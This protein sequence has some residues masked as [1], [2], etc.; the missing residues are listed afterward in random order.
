MRKKP[1]GV[2]KDVN[3]NAARIVR[4]T[5][6]QESPVNVLESNEETRRRRS[7]AAAILGRLGGAKGGHARA[8]N[9]SEERKSEIGRK[10][11]ETRW[12]KRS[13]DTTHLIR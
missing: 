1:A 6:G 11:A 2:P 8:A 9:L 13:V 10:A 5:T 12:K 3:Q 4:L 7:E